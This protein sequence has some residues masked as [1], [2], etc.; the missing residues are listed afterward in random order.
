MISYLEIP[1]SR[2]SS[3][4]EHLFVH[5]IVSVVRRKKKKKKKKKIYLP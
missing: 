5:L 2:N 4:L 3:S 1:A